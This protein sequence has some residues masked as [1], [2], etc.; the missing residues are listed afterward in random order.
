MVRNQIPP[1]RQVVTSPWF[2]VYRGSGVWSMRGSVL[3]MAQATAAAVGGQ[4][5]VRV[6]RGVDRVM[7]RWSGHGEGLM[8]SKVQA[9]VQ[10]LR[11]VKEQVA[12]VTAPRAWEQGTLRHPPS[13]AGHDPG[14]GA[15]GPRH[16]AG[17]GHRAADVPSLHKWLTEMYGVE[18]ARAWVVI[19]PLAHPREYLWKSPACTTTTTKLEEAGLYT[20]AKARDIASRCS[21]YYAAILDPMGAG[22]VSIRARARVTLVVDVAVNSTWGAGCELTQVYQQAR[23]EATL[24]VEA[25]L[26]DAL[27]Q[28][29]AKV[30]SSKVTAILTEDDSR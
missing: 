9:F 21:G 25:R 8:S 19:D 12:R 1:M 3:R 16:P 18:T 29:Q 27:G 22:A 13:A 4:A 30:L 11:E 23:D 26:R 14:D 10:Q 20:E 5:E 2:T 24:A 6:V 17:Y 7:A 15:R 28:V